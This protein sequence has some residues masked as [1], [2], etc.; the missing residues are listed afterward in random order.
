[1]ISGYYVASCKLSK[2]FTDVMDSVG[3]LLLLEK[4]HPDVFSVK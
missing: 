3:P 4:W 2:T 1:M